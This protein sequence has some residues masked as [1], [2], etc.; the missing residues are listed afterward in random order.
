MGWFGPGKP[1]SRFGKW[2]DKNG[3]TQQELSRRSGVSED[4]ISRLA[5]ND[6]GRPTWRTQKRLLKVLR[7]VDSEISTEDFW[8]K[9]D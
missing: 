2:L 8:E 4:T 9:D 5:N 6:S 1:R 7:E 3:I